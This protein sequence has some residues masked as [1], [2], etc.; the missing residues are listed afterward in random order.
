MTMEKMKTRRK[1]SRGLI[2][3]PRKQKIL[4]ALAAGMIM[5]LS[6]SPGQPIRILKTLPKIFKDIET[7]YFIRAVKEFH[8][9]RLVNYLENPNGTDIQI[10]ISELGRKRVLK[11]DFDK[12]EIKKPLIWD[13]KW[14]LVFFDVPEKKRLIRDSFRI[15]L[16]DLGFQELQRSIFIHPYPCEAEI[17]FAIEVLDARSYVR[18]AEV[19]W[20]TNEADLLLRFHLNKKLTRTNLTRSC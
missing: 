3:S 9:D 13:K 14:R 1:R 18:L 16:Q 10:T 11:F 2:W 5:G 12:L 19:D 6:R 7:K 17:N 4:V 15:K 8:R 20:I